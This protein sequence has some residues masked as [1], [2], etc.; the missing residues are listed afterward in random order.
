M[1]RRTLYKASFYFFIA[2][3]SKIGDARGSSASPIFD[4]EGSSCAK[5]NQSQS[6]QLRLSLLQR[7]V[8]FAIANAI[9]DNPRADLPPNMIASFE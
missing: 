1:A 7:F 6:S 5:L 3:T 8:P 4:W 9:R 2:D